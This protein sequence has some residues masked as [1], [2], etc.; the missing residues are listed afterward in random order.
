MREAAPGIGHNSLKGQ[1]IIRSNPE[2][3][4]TRI[5]NAFLQDSRVSY[6]TRGLLAELLSRPDD[7]HVTV[8]SIVK[9]GPAGRDKVYRMLKE[10]E[11]FG[12][13]ASARDRN[14]DGSFQK[15]QYVIT[16]DP[17]LLIARTAA[18]IEQLE[19]P[20]PENPEVVV[21]FPARQE[22]EKPRKQATS[23]KPVSGQPLPEN[24]DP[25][26]PL[27]ANPTHTKERYIQT[28]ETTLEGARDARSLSKAVAIGIAA[29]TASLPA[30]AAPVES[31]AITQPAK[32]EISYEEL[33]AKLMEAGGEAI[34]TVP[35][36]ELL[37]VP[38]A[39][40][41]AG[42][43]LTED[44]LPAIRAR[45]A[46]MPPRSINSWSYF[47]QKVADAK[48]N[49]LKPLPEGRAAPPSGSSNHWR[50]KERARLDAFSKL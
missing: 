31:P 17:K 19:Q 12:Y 5:S 47:S 27:P 3:G 18:E 40:L 35:G 1:T 43:D 15:Q 20:L 7:W 14:G 4:F 45:A 9:S 42:C 38:R 24:P 39:W 46:T 33:K 36:L 41:A 13:A 29:A 2:H 48:A 44:I 10:A 30:A 34:G 11:K 50:D 8:V 23:W 37:S 28:T 6:E 21:P 26:Q 22:P 16:D 49:R 25:A 32:Q